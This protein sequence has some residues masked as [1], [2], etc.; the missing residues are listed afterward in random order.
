[1]FINN[2]TT[3]NFDLT[4]AS[5]GLKKT[6]EHPVRPPTKN[7]VITLVHDNKALKTSTL[8]QHSWP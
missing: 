5:T 3:Y 6:D 7:I 4:L 1:M 8:I 2:S